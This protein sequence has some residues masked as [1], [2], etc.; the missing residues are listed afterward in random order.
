MRLPLPTDRLVALTLVGALVA[1]GA[2][3]ALATPGVLSPRPP[4]DEATLESASLDDA[5]GTTQEDPAR[6]IDP[7]PA[8]PDLVVDGSPADP[9]A[10]G[11]PS[12]E[13]PPFEDPASIALDE[14]AYAPPPMSEREYESMKKQLEWERE[15]AK[16]HAEGEDE[17]DR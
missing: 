13:L 2:A 15:L 7:P 6:P 11:G 5:S 1:G 17:E 16:Q 12:E 14:E 4:P 9:A 8:I 3:F 10:F